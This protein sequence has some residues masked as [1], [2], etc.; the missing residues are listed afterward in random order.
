MRMYD[1]ILKKRNGEALTD[2][3]IRYMVAGYVKGEIPDYQMSAMLMAI[4]FN[5]MDDRETAILTDAAARS[6]DM[7]DLSPIQGIK[8][9]KHSTG[10]G[11]QEYPGSGPY[12]GGLWSQGG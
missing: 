7:V 9:D 12:R 6:G 8:V 10:G 2:E 4:Y 5:G 3:E 11:R 1:V